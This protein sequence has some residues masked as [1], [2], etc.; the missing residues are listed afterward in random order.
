MIS[1]PILGCV[2]RNLIIFCQSWDHVSQ[3][4]MPTIES[5][6][7]LLTADYQPQLR[8]WIFNCG[9]NC[10]DTVVLPGDGVYAF[11]SRRGVESHRRRFCNNS[12]VSQLCW[13]CVDG[14]HVEI[15]AP[16]N[17]GS[18][19]YNN[20]G[21]F[22]I[23]LLAVVDARYHFLMVDVGAYG[24]S[25]DG[26]TLS[27]SAFGKVLRNKTRDLPTD[28]PLPGT[29]KAM[30]HVFATCILHNYIC[31]HSQDEDPSTLTLCPEPSPGMRSV[32]QVGSN[33]ASQ[34]ALSIRERF[35]TYLS[36][37]AGRASWHNAQ[38]H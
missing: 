17:S 22:S 4:R 25:S 18:I 8:G 33:W 11:S 10:R 1:E 37:P 9:G 27:S 35:A 28:Q 31:G 5:L 38:N 36:S 3:N 6:L 29:E 26:G 30:P 19:Y 21:S 14:K 16:A 7:G 13:S 20:K 34:E 32:V 12:R 2:E 23:V 15:Q 24:K